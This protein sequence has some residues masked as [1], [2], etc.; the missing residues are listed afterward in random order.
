MSLSSDATTAGD[1]QSLS[2][3]RST[4]LDQYIYIHTYICTYIYT[5]VYI[6]IYIYIYLY[7]YIHIHAY[8]YIYVYI[9]YS[10]SYVTK[11]EWEI[12]PDEC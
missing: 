2:L 12:N 6:Y 1:L 7:L 9:P 3:H 5:Y 10:G 11:Y 8:I 4:N